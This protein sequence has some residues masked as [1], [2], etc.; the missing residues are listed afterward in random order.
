MPSKIHWHRIPKICQEKTTLTKKSRH[1][2]TLSL[3]ILPQPTPFSEETKDR[4]KKERNEEVHTCPEN[5]LGKHSAHV[6]RVEVIKLLTDLG[7]QQPG[8]FQPSQYTSWKKKEEEEENPIE[9]YMLHVPRKKEKRK[10]KKCVNQT[11]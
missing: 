11:N 2:T 3:N 7:Y 6:P 1:S 8:T 4:E 9:N 10:K 5:G